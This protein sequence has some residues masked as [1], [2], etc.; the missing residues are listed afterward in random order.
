LSLDTDAYAQLCS[1]EQKKR[2]VKV[3]ELLALFVAS[4]SAPTLKKYVELLLESLAANFP[5]FFAT[6]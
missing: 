1:G 2:G 6:K 5:A 4:L 3:L